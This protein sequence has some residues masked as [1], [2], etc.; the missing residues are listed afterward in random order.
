MSGKFRP[1]AISQART[2]RGNEVMGQLF[3]A[4]SVPV[5]TRATVRAFFGSLRIMAIDGTVVD[6][7]DTADNAAEFGYSGA[8]GGKR[9]AFPQVRI[10]GGRDEYRQLFEAIPHEKSIQAVQERVCDRSM[11]QLLRGMLRAGVMQTIKKGLHQQVPRQAPHF[12][13]RRKLETERLGHG[14]RSGTTRQETAGTKASAL[15]A[16]HR[17]RASSRPYS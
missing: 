11:V 16:D 15:T 4:V 6:T 7:P 12:T 8:A 5:A 17:H 13:P 10:V 9:S 1:T 14:H 2:Q 3:E